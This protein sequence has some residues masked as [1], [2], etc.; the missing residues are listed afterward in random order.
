MRI[1]EV[2]ALTEVSRHTVRYYERIGLLSAPPRGANN[3][4]EYSAACVE[5]LR[6]IRDAQQMGFTL[7]EIR[8][9][10]QLQREGA[11]NCAEGARLIWAKRQ[12]VQ[13]RLA[14][15]QRLDS[16]LASEQQRL[17][18]SAQ[19]HGY[20]LAAELKAAPASG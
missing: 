7:E 13:Q 17:T 11:I 16:Y 3:Y 20:P 4:R 6:F 18:A 1:A 14:Q 10:V 15:L 19:A 9:I 8:H 5:Q 12:E 2:E